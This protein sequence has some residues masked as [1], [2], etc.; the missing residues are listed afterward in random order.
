MLR[1]T[2]RRFA[3]LC[4]LGALACGFAHVQTARADDA[5]GQSTSNSATSSA[6][7]SSST[8]QT[9]SQTQTGGNAGGGQSQTS[10]QTASTDQN[11]GATATA[12][13][14]PTNIATGA[15]KTDQKKHEL[16]DEHGRERQLDGAEQRADADR[17]RRA[18]RCRRCRPG[19]ELDAERSDDPDRAVHGDVDS[20]VAVE[21]EYRGPR[22]E[23]GQQRPGDPDEHL[24][25]GC[26]GREYEPGL[27][28]GVP[29]SERWRHAERSSSASVP[30]R[31]NHTG[32][33]GV[34][35]LDTAQSAEREHLG[36]CR[37]PRQQRSRGADEQFAGDGGSDERERGHSILIASADSR[38]SRRRAVAGCVAKCPDL[39]ERNLECG[40][41]A[42]ARRRTARSR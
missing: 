33:W 31:A 1:S 5:T 26:R 13:Q 38:R 6:T 21:R 17:V 9:S 28:N 2:R 40:V 23:P 10:V 20:A 35:S 37:K 16:R 7:N 24:S 27:A 4:A 42:R 25:G 41:D 39:P 11:A 36:S 29:G 8:S 15:G 30:E 34:R 18:F 32:G 22:R 12:T 14:T 3:L 19:P